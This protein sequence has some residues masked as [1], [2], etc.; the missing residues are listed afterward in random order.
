MH[1]LPALLLAAQPAAPPAPAVTT[2][3][4]RANV[5]MLSG[6]GGNLGL[7]TGADG[8]LLIDDQFAR[9][10]GAIQ[11][12][13]QALTTE[14]LRFVINTHWHGDHTGGNENFRRAGAIIVAHDNVRRR[15]TSENFLAAFN[16]RVPPSPA[17]ALPVVTFSDS[18]NFHWNGEDVRVV[19]VQAAHTDGDAVVHF[20]RANVVHMGDVYFNGM[21]PFID[22]STGGSISGM[23]EAVDLVLQSANPDTK[24]I[25]GHGPLSGLAELRAYRDMLSAVELRVRTLIEQGKTREAV[26]AARPGADYDAKWG[27]GFI[28]PD[29]FAGLV[30][31]GLAR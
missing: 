22:V 2:V 8:A 18:V 3:P 20:T 9:S 11:A 21:Y 12:A 28:R 19:H 23:V 31:D 24:F 17:G 30:F 4:V 26:V 10:T 15:M 27:Q 14:P 29:V 16:M 7:L 25:P 5:Y 13:V 1:L 6:E